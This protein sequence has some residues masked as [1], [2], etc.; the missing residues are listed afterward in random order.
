VLPLSIWRLL[1]LEIIG[2]SKLRDIIPKEECALDVSVGIIKCIFLDEKGNQ[3][4]ETKVHSFLALTDTVPI[5]IGFKDLLDRFTL[6]S[7]YPNEA[8]IEE[9]NI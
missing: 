9:K 1:D 6:H 8:W 5:L 7:D 3:T 4:S 2:A